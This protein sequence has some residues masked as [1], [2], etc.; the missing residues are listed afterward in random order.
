MWESIF[1]YIDTEGF[2]TAAAVCRLFNELA[3]VVYL[4]TRGVRRDSLIAGKLEIVS[5]LILVL[6]A[7]LSLPPTLTRL[8]CEFSDAGANGGFGEQLRCLRNVVLR[9]S[10]LEELDLRFPRGSFSSSIPSQTSTGLTE[11]EVDKR[12][13][14][15]H[16]VMLAMAQGPVVCVDPLRAFCCEPLDLCAKQ[17][18]PGY[19]APRPKTMRSRDLFGLSQWAHSRPW[20]QRTPQSDPNATRTYPW[21]HVKSVAVRRMRSPSDARPSYTLVI[22]DEEFVQELHLGRQKH[23]PQSLQLSGRQLNTILPHLT[24]PHICSLELHTGDIDPRVFGQ[25]LG[26]HET[27][28]NLTYSDHDSVSPSPGILATPQ[29]QLP[30]LKYLASRNTAALRAVLYA[31]GP[32]E[33]QTISLSFP[34]KKSKTELKQHRWLL[35]QIAARAAKQTTLE[36]HL[37][38]FHTQQ[39]DEEDKAILQSLRCVSSVKLIGLSRWDFGRMEEILPW[40]ALLPALESFEV[41]VLMTPN[42]EDVD[43]AKEWDKFLTQVRIALPHLPTLTKSDTYHAYLTPLDT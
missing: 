5:P 25:F 1:Y 23:L 14:W 15:F 20:R 32:S 31:I 21:P 43:L 3:S 9:C 29:V 16:D 36:I 12:C 33:Q 34:N 39:P 8:A 13:N 11:D 6:G 27:L 35:R 30:E 17:Y 7:S 10:N 4:V 24:L 38:C 26:R 28:K 41:V 42:P 22:T 2:A 19:F 37:P 18:A 40:L